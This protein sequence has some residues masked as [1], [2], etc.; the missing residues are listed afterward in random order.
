MESWVLVAEHEDGKTCVNVN[1]ISRSDISTHVEVKRVYLPPIVDEFRGK[2]VSSLKT[3]EEHDLAN[4]KRRI[5]ARC[6]QYTDGSQRNLG[7]DG[8][9]TFIEMESEARS[10]F[11]EIVEKGPLVKPGLPSKTDAATVS[12]D[13]KK[14]L[15]ERYG[16]G[17]TL[18]RTTYDRFL[19][20]NKKRSNLLHKQLNCLQW[21]SLVLAILILMALQVLG[22]R[23]Y[24]SFPGALV[25]YLLFL[26][27]GKNFLVNA[28][29]RAVINFTLDQG[30]GD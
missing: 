22:I 20:F 14:E 4:R 26:H 17:R 27:G 8:Y 9:W 10:R 18:G 11:I 12:E 15:R 23:W 13:R 28:S 6:Y 30:E 24:F 16:H 19:E 21:T 2:S 5:H 3:K 7:G 25:F 1:S 29:R